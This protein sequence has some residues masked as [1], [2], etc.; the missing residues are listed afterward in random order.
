MDYDDDDESIR[1][2]QRAF[3]LVHQNIFKIVLNHNASL[4]ELNVGMVPINRLEE[5]S[6]Q[7]AKASEATR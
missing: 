5:I 6:K 3:D 7:K 4:L 1:V 2:S